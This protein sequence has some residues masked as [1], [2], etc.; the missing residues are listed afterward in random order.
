MGIPAIPRAGRTTCLFRSLAVRGAGDVNHMLQAGEDLDHNG[1]LCESFEACAWF[2]GPTEGDSVLVP[3]V[4][5]EPATK[6]LGISL[7]PQ[8]PK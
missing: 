1:F 2:G 3:F 4:L 5:A 7:V 6:G 8:P